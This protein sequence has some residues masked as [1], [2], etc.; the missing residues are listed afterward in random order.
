MEG[1]YN[2]LN[3]CLM[4]TLHLQELCVRCSLDQW[5]AFARWPLGALLF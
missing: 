3:K 4:L 2:L 5:I 1:I